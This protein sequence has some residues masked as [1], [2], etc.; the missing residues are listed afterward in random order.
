M[1]FVFL[2]HIK[3]SPALP[4]SS[5][6][7]QEFTLFVA[8]CG[9]AAERRDTDCGAALG[10]SS[11]LLCLW[12]WEM[13]T[14]AETQNPERNSSSSGLAGTTGP[15]HFPSYPALELVVCAWK[16]DVFHKD[17]QSPWHRKPPPRESCSSSSGH[18]VR[19]II[20]LI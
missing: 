10:P 5:P 18:P 20:Y 2:H 7:S 1:V 8:L 12:P 3:S 14:R 15:R 6:K 17:I 4:P 16:K 19:T 13:L 9:E 11:K